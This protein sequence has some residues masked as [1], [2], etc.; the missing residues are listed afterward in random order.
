MLAL[1]RRIGEKIL[2]GDEIVITVTAASS[3][4]SQVKIG[5][6]APRVVAVHREEIYQKIQE[7][8]ANQNNQCS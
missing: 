4:S 1:T 8:K 5:I 7:K 3:R 6:D 2:I